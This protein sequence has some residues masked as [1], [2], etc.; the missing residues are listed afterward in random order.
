[1][2][3]HCW[4]VDVYREVPSELVPEITEGYVRLFYTIY[5]PD[6]HDINDLD[7]QFE[8]RHPE[9]HIWDHDYLLKNKLVDIYCNYGTWIGSNRNTL[10]LGPWSEQELLE[11]AIEELKA[12]RIRWK[13]DT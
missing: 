9:T 1:M 12:K 3:S 6:S 2:S 4:A 10:W 7:Y 5:I 11:F 8:Q 13:W